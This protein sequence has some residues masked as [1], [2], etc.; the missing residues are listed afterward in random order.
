MNSRERVLAT[1]TG[2]EPDRVPIGATLTP[3]V[4]NSLAKRVDLRCKKQPALLS[5]RI[6]YNNILTKLGNDMVF[7]GACFP[8]NYALEV[9]KLGCFIDEWGIKRRKVGYYDE[10]VK[11]P[12]ASVNIPE[13]VE[14]HFKKY[15]FPD[16]YAG[17]RFDFAENEIK[18]YRQDY[19]I[20]GVVECTIFELSWY[21][22]GLEK[23]LIDLTEEK[24]YAFTLLD[25][26][27][28]FNIELGK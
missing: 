2:R 18:N 16:P 28:N 27:M 3:Q 6:S 26:V 13:D 24:E 1:L 25:R 7:V 11:Y 17:G 10:I 19:G 23:F 12:L 15:G 21:L 22:A 8:E 14:R 5:D 20:I 9:D 4:A